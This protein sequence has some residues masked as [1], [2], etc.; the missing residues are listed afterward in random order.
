VKSDDIRLCEGIL[1]D[2]PDIKKSLKIRELE[3]LTKGF[4]E[5]NVDGGRYIPKEQRIVEDREYSELSRIVETITRAIETLSKDEQEVVRLVYF[6]GMSR[7]EAGVVMHCCNSS[8]RQWSVRALT[9]IK[10]RVLRLLPSVDE[11]R[12]KN[13][14]EKFT[15]P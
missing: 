3:I 10:S 11:W 6:L 12:I 2:Y 8:I 14:D 5:E 9:K 1:R 4:E 7:T 15:T 13:F